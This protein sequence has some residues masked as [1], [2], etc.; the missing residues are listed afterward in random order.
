MFY[1]HKKYKKFNKNLRN[2]DS[3]ED[4]T[5][6]KII[7]TENIDRKYKEQINNNTI[8]SHPLK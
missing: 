3:R 5:V 4:W 7:L 6:S 2:V 1:I 8:R